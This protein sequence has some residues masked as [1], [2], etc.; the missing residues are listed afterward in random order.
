MVAKWQRRSWSLVSL[1]SVSS[2]PEH[3]SSLGKE[4]QLI[5]FVDP[6]YQ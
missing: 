2:R 6:S 3:S 5:D 1:V 4:K